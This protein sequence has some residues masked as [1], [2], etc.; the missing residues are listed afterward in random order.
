M[1][2]I[3][4][5]LI[6][7]IVCGPHG[8]GLVSDVNDVQMLANIGIMLLLFSVG[9]EFSISKLLESKRFFLIGGTLQVFLTTLLGSGI[10]VFLGQSLGAALFFG[11]FVSLSS[12]AIVMRML[13]E[14]AES[15]SPHG[16]IMLSILIFQDIIVIP[17]VLLTPM[18]SGNRTEVDSNFL[19]ATIKGIAI[20]IFVFLSAELAVPRLLHYIAKTRN[21]E[22]FLLGVLTICSTVAW[23]SSSAGVSLS[24][25]AF[26]AGLI[27]SESEYSH[28][29]IGDILPFQDIFT[30]FFFVSMG[31][32]LD[33][34]FL[35]HHPLIVLGVALG[36]MVLK[37]AIIGSITLLLGMPLRTAVL[38]GFSLCQIGEFSFVLAK[39][40]MEYQI[41]SEFYY[42]LFLAVC[43][44][45]MALTPLLIT[46]SPRL[47]VYF[48]KMPLP[49][50][51]KF[52][53]NPIEKQEEDAISDHV[54]IIG[55]GLCGRS[56][57][58]ATREAG[59]PYIILD[60]NPERVR[61]EKQRDEPIHFGDATHEAVLHH[62][63]L[64]KAKVV[65]VAINDPTAA[66][67]IVR[68]VRRIH[69]IVHL[70]VRTNF[71]QEVKIMYKAGADDV[72]SDEFGSS[73]E[74]FSR[75]LKKY[76]VHIE[77]I[78]R[79]IIDQRIENYD[80]QRF[81]YRDSSLF[82]GFDKAVDGIATESCKVGSLSPLVGKSIKESNLRSIHGVTVLLIYRGVEIIP[83][84]NASTIIFPGD[85]FILMG[86][87][88]S[89]FAVTKLFRSVHRSS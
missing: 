11:F 60:M 63:N 84:P 33:I 62:A 32:L 49:P 17:M 72:I 88:D 80:I 37:T 6:T 86:T 5:F 89:L 44:M 64:L 56:L 55:M 61:L 7:G 3:V 73:I 26:M 45:T 82:S 25:G 42:Q 30:S 69:P 35:L 13:E 51:L 77:D 24:L 53:L 2:T 12:T 22:L 83:N 15:G 1:P 40:G 79:Y 85:I 21:R 78:G 38:C 14:R 16:R 58:R 34:E 19:F 9:M 20:L 54:I 43:L 65:A 47:A 18:L 87:L 66:I 23:V 50:L 46:L 74:I 52:G 76:D 10:A 67:R 28:E 31:M 75:V 70:V 8:L 48:S 71:V 4:G 57:A 27:I 81:L 29:A 68:K 39:T 36:V 41:A 59:I